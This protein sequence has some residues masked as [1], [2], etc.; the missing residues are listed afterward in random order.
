MKTILFYGDSN[1]WG[2]NA[3]NGERYPRDV[4]FTGLLAA[5]MPEYFI[6]E[7]GLNGRT[8]VTDDILGPKRNGYD[9]L[10]MVL[11]S[12]SPVDL[13]VV[14]LG[15]NDTKT[16]FRNSSS[17]I[18]SGLG[19][20]INVAQ[21]PWL[22]HGKKVPEILVVCPPLVTEDING[23]DMADEFSMYSVQ[24]S[25]ELSEKYKVVADAHGCHFLDAAQVT[26]PGKR[27]GVHLDPEGHRK[28]AAALEKRIREIL[29]A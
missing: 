13:M 7:E 25:K 22:W 23:S 19:M 9:T 2:Y 3:K 17:D 16:R 5:R 4:R 15:T 29:S 28:M 11:Y 24:V 27:D 8:N 6:V 1:T 20:V 12:Q 14:M 21:T 26:G 18:A 10:P